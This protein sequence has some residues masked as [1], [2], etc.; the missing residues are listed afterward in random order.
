MDIA[1][2]LIFVIPFNDV[3][4]Y[5]CI[6]KHLIFLNVKDFCFSGLCEQVSVLICKVDEYLLYVKFE[7]SS[8]IPAIFFNYSNMFTKFM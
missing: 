8:I 2:E 6:L 4:E 7:I 3:E 5:G 1:F